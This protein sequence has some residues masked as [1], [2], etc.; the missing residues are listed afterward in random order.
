[1]KEKNAQFSSVEEKKSILLVEDDFINREILSAI[2]SEIYDIIVAETGEE[3][4]EIISHRYDTISIMLLDLNLPGISGYDVL[5]RLKADNAYSRIPIIVVTADSEAE[6]ECLNLG[7]ID[8]IPKPYPQ[9]KVILARILRTIE[10]SE[11]RD[12]IRYTERDNLTGV[13]NKEFFYRYASQLDIYHYDEPYDA[14]VLDV[15]RFHTI[16]ARY[17]KE[18]GDSILKK[19]AEKAV[20]S[21]RNIGGIVC[22]SDADSF[23]IYCPHLIDY[24]KLLKA[25]S[26]QINSEETGDNRVHIRMGVYPEVDKS[27]DIERRLDCAKMA[28]DVIRGSYTNAVSLYDNAIYEKEILSEQLI[29]D[30]QTAINEKQFQVYYQPKYYING[31]KPILASAEAL[32]RWK[33]PKFG[34]VSPGDFI[35]LF[36]NNGLIQKLDR[37]IWK[38]AAAQIKRWKD[39]YG[40]YFPVSVNV[41]RVDFFNPAL[42]EILTEIIKSNGLAP[43][44]LLLEITESAYTDNA[45]QIVDVIQNLHNLGFK[46]E[47]DDFGCGYSS[48]NMLTSLPFDAL[49]LDRK[50]IQNIVSNEKDYRL[51]GIIIDIARLLDVPVIAEGVETEAQMELLKKV[52][53]DIIQGFY[54]SKPLPANEFEMLLKT[55]LKEKNNL[56]VN[57]RTHIF[58]SKELKNEKSRI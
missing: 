56:F 15:N 2:L 43:E 34:M 7:A 36:E 13:Y 23:M 25:V 30:F 16:N 55:V 12:T 14:I 35:S 46:I 48:L 53:C 45:E 50:F 42:S 37:Y 10:L 39:M 49:K 8:F 29:E 41:S 11:D 52:G 26:V 22:R 57:G 5:K 54:F 27:L 51:V 32:V 20:E 21:V 24:N 38:E 19:I 40:I 9:P 28:A 4:L 58:A 47:M 33:H 1:M 6:V 18:Y 3:A 44:N 31:A 17:G